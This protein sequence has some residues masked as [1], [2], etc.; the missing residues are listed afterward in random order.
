VLIVAVTTWQDYEPWVYRGGIVVAGVAATL[1]V[2]VVV[3]PAS[4]VGRVLGIAPL[5]WIGARSYGIYLFHWPVMVL[6][7]PGIDLQW[8]LW[9]LVPLQIALTIGL[10]AASYRWIE[11]PIRRGEAGPAIRA[12]LDRRT[13][14]RRL[15]VAL[16]GVAVLAG[17][18][19]AIAAR[20]VPAPELPP[21]ANV[22]ATAQ[23]KAAPGALLSRGTAPVGEGSAAGGSQKRLTGRS[24]AVGASVMLGSQAALESRITVD[25]AVARQA[26][27]IIARLQAFRDAGKLPS[28]VIVQIGENGPLLGDQVLALKEVLRGVDRVVLVNIR[29]PRR[30]EGETNDLLK[31]TAANWKEAELADWHGASGGSGVL[32]D[33][34]IHPTPKGQEIYARVIKRA[35]RAP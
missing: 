31:E 23:A 19:T 33:D 17:A 24:L 22:K 25:A 29:V 18:T 15:A 9:V 6:T 30:W 26:T 21:I 27:D 16:T 5:V 35:L 20:H 4:R 13:P 12:W 1:L 10:A 7:R 8:S 3:H 14:R 11:M 2:A 34:G 28:R 32:W